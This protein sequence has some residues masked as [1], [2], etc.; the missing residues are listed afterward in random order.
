GYYFFASK[1]QLEN[2]SIPN[3]QLGYDFNDHWGI[4]AG[5]AVINTDQ[6]ASAGGEH[7]HGFIY[8]V[9]GLYHFQQFGHVEPYLMAGVGVTGL[10]PN[11]IDPT[12]QGNVDA[13]VG[14]QYFMTD[15]IALGADAKDVYTL[16]GGKNDAMVTAGITFLFGGQTSQPESPYKSATT[17]T[18]PTK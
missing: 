1:R 2:T 14:V 5:V 18:K 8:S 12:N 13:G 15:S 4:Q 7:V 9:D 10:K 11:G 17:E 6:N 3:A 16:S